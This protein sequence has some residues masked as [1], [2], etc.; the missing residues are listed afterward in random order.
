MWFPYFH[1]L[2]PGVSSTKRGQPWTKPRWLLWWSGPHPR[3]W[4]N[5]NASLAW[6]IFTRGSF[7]VSAPLP[8]N[9]LPFL[10][11]KGPKWLK[12]D[13]ADPIIKHLDQSKPFIMEVIASESGLRAV[14]SQCFGEK[15]T[16]HP[17]SF[18]SKKLSPVEQNYDIGNHEF[19]AVKL[20][21]E[22]WCHWVEG[23]AYPFTIFTDYKN[24]EYLKTAKCLNPHQAWW[25]LFF[26]RFHF[27]FS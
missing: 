15:H 2:I 9:S 18:F 11:K 14:L 16:L 7:R 23:A 12:W 17:V 24:L 1:N 8:P 19:L 3:Q 26:T 21:L 20:A 6:P 25:V 4:R 13:Q 22:E 27:N 10:K 5:S